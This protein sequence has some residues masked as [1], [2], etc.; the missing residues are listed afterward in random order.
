MASYVLELIGAS[1]WGSQYTGAADEVRVW[2]VARSE[3]EIQAAMSDTLDL[4]VYGGSGSDLIA[5][6]RFDEI[7]DLGIGGDGADDV[8]DYSATGHHGDIVGGAM[9]DPIVVGVEPQVES[10]SWAR[11]KTY[12][13]EN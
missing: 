13:L 5:Y 6:Y 3:L 10:T 9:L 1:S 11:L 2:K 7:E 12:F 8:R 4:T